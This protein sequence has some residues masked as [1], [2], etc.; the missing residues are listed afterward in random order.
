MVVA[1]GDEVNA[2]SVSSPS[3]RGHDAALPDL[4]E[5]GSPRPALLSFCLW[6]ILYLTILVRK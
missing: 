6:F 4:G 5:G 3:R 1:E 2:C